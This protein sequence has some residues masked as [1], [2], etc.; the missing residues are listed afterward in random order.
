LEVRFHRFKKSKNGGRES[1][2]NCRIGK[3][4]RGIGIRCWYGGDVG[5]KAPTL[6]QN[7]KMDVKRREKMAGWVTR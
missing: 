2:K 1:G 3:T 7:V 5:G 4:R 6:E